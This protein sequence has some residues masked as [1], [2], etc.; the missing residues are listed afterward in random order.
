MRL[1]GN[2]LFVKDEGSQYSGFNL[3]VSGHLESGQINEYDGICAK[4]DFIAGVDWS[5]I[6][7]NRTG[8]S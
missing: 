4:Y 5:I 3:V 7:G 1:G 6:E 2:S 8:V